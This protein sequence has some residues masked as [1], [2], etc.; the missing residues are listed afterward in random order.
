[1]SVFVKI[2]E[3]DIFL[4]EDID[5]VNSDALMLNTEL[6]F[7]MW[8]QVVLN[9]ANMVSNVVHNVVNAGGDDLADGVAGQHPVSHVP[10]RAGAAR[11]VDG[12]HPEAVH[13]LLHCLPERGPRHARQLQHVRPLP[14]RLAAQV[15]NVVHMWSMSSTCG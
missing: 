1:M 7:K 2:Y 13:A 9:V 15:F 8:S 3:P 10:L 12:T 6:Q 14:Q 5:D 11:G 4:V